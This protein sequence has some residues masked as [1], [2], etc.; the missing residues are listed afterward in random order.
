MNRL[1][2]DQRGFTLVEM[3]VTLA[4][5][6]VVMGAILGLLDMS[7]RSSAS[8]MG[9]SQA[10][11]E[12]RGAIDRVGQE[13]RLASCQDSGTAVLS[14]T[15]DSVSYYVERPQSDYRLAN[16]VERHTLTYNDSAGTI[17]LTVSPGTGTP[18]TWG[19]TTRTTVL[20]NGLS[21]TGTT[22]I[23]QYLGY[24][25]PT[26]PDTTLITAPVAAASLS[27]VAQVQVTFTAL[28]AYPSRNQG[29]SSFQSSILLRTDDPSD[30]DNT[31]EC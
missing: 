4:I 31:P 21:R 16:V 25:S 12:G 9:R 7:V 2:A 5:S 13:L 29:A 24:V 6:M 30:E 23:F 8:S 26:A 27:S 11:R 20:G 10:V 1:R 15:D 18:P 17:T 28:G 22:P 14:A 19:A 3:L